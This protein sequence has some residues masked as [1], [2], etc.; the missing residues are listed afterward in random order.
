MSLRLLFGLRRM[1]VRARF[2]QLL[3]ESRFKAVV[4][5]FL[6]S[7]FW[8][9]FF[10]AFLDGFRFL[11]TFQGITAAMNDILFAMFFVSLLIMLTFSNAIICFSSLYRSVEVEHF[12]S[13]PVSLSSL[14][15]YKFTESLAFSSW[16]FVLLAVPFLMAY[17]I[18][19]EASPVFYPAIFLF[20]VPFVVIPGAFGMLITLFLTM[21]FPRDRGKILGAVIVGVIVFFSVLG[22]TLTDWN[23]NENILNIHWMRG[24]IGKLAFSQNPYLPSQWIA[25]GLIAAA[26]GMFS[27]AVF[28]L[29]LLAANA[30]FLYALFDGAC[31]LWFRASWRKAQEATSPARRRHSIG[32]FRLAGGPGDMLLL[33]DVKTFVRDPV[34]WSQCAILFGILGLYILNLRNFNYHIAGPFWKNVVASL[35]LAATCLTL[36]TLTTRFVFPMISLEGQRFWILGLMPVSRWKILW[37]KFLFILSG[38]FLVTLVLVTLSNVMLGTMLEVLL[39]QC[40]TALMV[41]TGLAGLTVGMGVIFPN[42]KETDPSKIVSGFG[43]TFTLVLSMLYVGT[44][45]A[46]VAVPCHYYL[47]QGA[48]TG[49]EFRLGIGLSLGFA[50]LLTAVVCIVPLWLGRRAFDRLEF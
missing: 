21:F 34:Q 2:Q 11:N 25:R 8:L 26:S 14:L 49:R 17:G 29:L 10:F 1:I 50:S 12:L 16:A 30:M 35:N 37:T 22:L 13:A 47:V 42:F 23:P 27:D 46:V 28:Y 32:S 24:A 33:K 3:K 36:A 15:F 6:A 19:V 39:L 7:V 48:L 18:S 31:A 38:S 44:M 41:C 40:L 20:F 9:G 4:V 5:V 43:G 45:V